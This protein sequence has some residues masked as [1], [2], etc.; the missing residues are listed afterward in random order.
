MEQLNL[1]SIR[2]LMPP[3]NFPKDSP[4]FVVV[5]GYDGSGVAFPVPIDGVWIYQLQDWLMSYE[6][7][8]DERA[9]KQS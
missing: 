2:V 5:I 7:Q 8:E 4:A 3:A 1:F 9:A 6:A